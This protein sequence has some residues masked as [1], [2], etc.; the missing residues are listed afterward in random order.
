VLFV[1]LTCER[2]VWLARVSNESRRAEDKLTDPVQAVGL[3]HGHDPFS[4]MPGDP[5]LRIDTTR[6][7]PAEA[8]AR[9]AAHYALPLVETGQRLIP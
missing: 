3:F 4:T 6:L 7:L 5:S 1:H 9:I 8:A 2:D